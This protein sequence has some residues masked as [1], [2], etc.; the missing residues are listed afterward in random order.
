MEWDLARYLLQESKDVDEKDQ[1]SIVL[2]LHLF[3]IICPTIELS[4][5]SLIQVGQPFF[6]PCMLSE[7]Y[8]GP[9]VWQ[10]VMSTSILLLPCL[11]FR[12][13]QFDS[14]LEVLFSA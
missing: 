4:G 10:G 9:F 2:L 11:V 7:E 8:E 13:Q 12:P 14:F 5:H 1:E 3:T 6:V